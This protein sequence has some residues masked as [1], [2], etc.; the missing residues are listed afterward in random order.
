MRSPGDVELKL[1]TMVRLYG[2][3]GDRYV[4]ASKRNGPLGTWY[5]FCSAGIDSPIEGYGEVVREV[6]SVPGAAS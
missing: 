1:G 3:A 4:V 6:L 5:T 2:T